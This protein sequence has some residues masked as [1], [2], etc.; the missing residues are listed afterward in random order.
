MEKT[1]Q[2]D[3]ASFLNWLSQ[4]RQKVVGYLYLAGDAAIAA[5]GFLG[6]RAER[7]A[8]DLTAVK[9][10]KKE[11][12]TGLIWA[13]G[14]A[15]MGFYGN[16]PLEKQMKALEQRLSAHFAEQ[17]LTLSEELLA[18]ATKEKD[19][20]FFAK[21]EDFLYKYPTE[22]LNAIYALGSGL[23][24][25]QGLNQEIFSKD[26]ALKKAFENEGRTHFKLQDIQ[27][28]STLGMGVLIMAGALSGLLIKHK[29]QEQIEEEGIGAFRGTLHKNASMINGGLYLA[30]NAFTIN[31]IFK[32]KRTY[33]NAAKYEQDFFTR[34]MYSLRIV[35]AASYIGANIFL[36]SG[37]SAEKAAA[38]QADNGKQ[39]ILAGCVQIIN[40]QPPELR[41]TLIDET[42]K[43][44]CQ[45]RELG[46]SQHAPKRLAARLR[47]AFSQPELTSATPAGWVGKIQS[48]PVS[49]GPTL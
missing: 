13:A 17:G 24:I 41:E 8:R 47:E 43:Y 2:A 25:S 35:T 40:A 34:N 15:A 3:P 12:T 14:G 9:E 29:S 39:E 7:K 22:I 1:P 30:N 48:Q 38:A 31:G 21:L 45:Q 5:N 10:Y 18:K 49:E 33:Q 44:L 42:A 32:N 19:K 28:I 16:R 20:G 4:N 26:S 36:A 37:S 27:H 11:L 23:L 46:F 6:M